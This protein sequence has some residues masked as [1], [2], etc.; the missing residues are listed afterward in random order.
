[1]DWI[2]DIVQFVGLSRLELGFWSFPIL[3]GLIFLRAPIGLAMFL[4]GLLGWIFAMN[5]NPIPILAKLKSE[6]Y[7]T[8]SNYSLTII[9]MFL[10]MGQ[11]ATLSG[12]STALFKAAEGFLGHRRGGVAMAAVG[13]CAGFGAICG[14]SL[15]TAATM[16]RVALPELKRYGYSGGFSTATLA[17]GGT[18]GILIPPSVILVIYAIITEQNIAKLFLA[19]FVPGILA[20]IGYVITISIYVR[21]FP[22][23]AGTRPPVPMAERWK[24]LGDTWPVLAIF[25]IVVGGIYAGWFT[26]TEGAAIGAA[27]TGFVALVGGNLTWAV[28]GEALIG[29]AKTTAM[30]FFIVL[31]ASLYNNFLALSGAPQWLADYVLNQGFTPILVLSVILV[32]YLVFGCVMDSLSMILLTVPIFF[33]VIQ[34]LDFGMTPEHVAIWFGILVLIVVEVGLITPPVGMNLFIINAMDRTTPMTETYKAVLFF[35]GSDIVRVVLL[36]LFPAI[37]L[38]LIP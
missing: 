35:V 23:S 26:P 7:T 9:P 32:F 14:S 4:C 18:L 1:M 33:P 25:A 10:L 16:S 19:A 11:F 6:T 24:A 37:T 5:G 13:A 3:L 27:G 28:L 30:I 15:A 20:A 34:G 21:L 22:G 31:G 2:R 12:M 29:T 8:F 36:V 38:F 17:A